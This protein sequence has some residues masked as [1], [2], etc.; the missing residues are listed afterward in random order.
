MV[1]FCW[2][3]LHILLGA[4]KNKFYLGYFSELCVLFSL[5]NLVVTSVF[6]VDGREEVECRPRVP[7]GSDPDGPRRSVRPGLFFGRPRWTGGPCRKGLLH[8]QKCPRHHRAYYAARIP[9]KGTLILWKRTIS[10]LDVPCSNSEA[11]RT[12]VIFLTKICVNKKNSLNKFSWWFFWSEI[13]VFWVHNCHSWLSICRLGLKNLQNT[14]EQIRLSRIIV[15]MPRKKKPDLLKL[16]IKKLFQCD[17][18]F[19]GS[20]LCQGYCSAAFWGLP[21]DGVVPL[22]QRNP[23]ALEKVSWSQVR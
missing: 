23:R 22:T 2:I 16:P 17:Y 14:F 1:Y 18:C 3:T 7:P 5:L 8:P 20:E 12:L 19:A 15:K 6:S 4:F 10:I 21:A 11:F 13:Q 9:D